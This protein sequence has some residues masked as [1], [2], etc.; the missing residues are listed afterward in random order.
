MD[1]STVQAIHC[2]DSVLS[3]HLITKDVLGQVALPDIEE[4]LK[5]KI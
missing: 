2:P 3:G 4:L 1:S 5:N